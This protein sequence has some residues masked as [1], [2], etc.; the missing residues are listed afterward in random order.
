M[1]AH[2]RGIARPLTLAL[3]LAVAVPGAPAGAAQDPLPLRRVMLSTGGVAYLEHEATVDGDATLPLTV[4]LAQVD[5][6]LKSLV[7]Y[8]DRGGVATIS[9]PGREPL[10]EAF[11]ELP[12]GRDALGS[13]VSLLRALV[14]AEVRVAGARTLEGRIL[15]VTAE[16]V[17][18]PGGLGK[19]TRHRVSVVVPAQG[20][21]QFVLEEADHVEFVD[22]T[23]RAQVSAALAAIARHRIQDRRTLAVSLRGS[24]PRTVRVGYVVEAPLWKASYRLTV[25]SAAPAG[26]G[27]G[28]GLLQGWAIVENLSGQDWDEV[29]LT[30]VSGNPVTFRQALY[31]AYHVAR[32]EVPV[33]V[34]GRVL[35][36]VDTG[37][38]DEGRRAE[39]Q[40]RA[41]GAPGRAGAGLLAAPL[42][43][44]RPVELPAAAPPAVAI[45]VEEAS[46]QV[47]FRVPTPV[48]LRS[49]SSLVIPIASREVPTERLALY[50]AAASAFHPLAAVRLRNDTGASLPPGVLTLY[51]RAAQG[52]S[53]FVGDAR[54]GPLPAGDSRLL[55]FAVDQKT[56]VAADVSSRE[57]IGTARISRGVLQLGLVEQQTTRYRVKA[58]AEEPRTLLIEHPRRPDWRL[59]VPPEREAE[60]TRDR[61]RVRAVLAP[62]EGAVVDVTVERPRESRLEIADMSL[63]TLAGYARTGA[64]DETVRKAFEALAA[65]RRDVDREQQALG[66]AESQRTTIH[67]EQ[68]RIRQNLGRVPATSDLHQRYL[69][70]LKQQEDQLQALARHTRETQARLRA[71]RD[72][73]AEAIARL[74]L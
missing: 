29:E 40:S 51:E 53:A 42:A 60:V 23:L 7:V 47:L 30:L 20:V 49:G 21:R 44:Q 39:V 62:G 4:R 26:A 19:T 32:P 5:D 74:E 52:E 15:G 18:L 1:P 71:A 64:L 6:V 61:Y 59:V 31:T 17:A 65:L 45:P 41:P 9:L 72:R 33:E 11:R 57:V 56:Q 46:S 2:A 73:L 36:R 22:P 16:E 37:T 24:G 67:A 70:M 55:S 10:E 35:P 3:L 13:P 54:L 25:A 8:D 66:E 14:G 28:R 34:M 43:A 68:D 63:A 69:D 58:P 50:E 27:A 12:F 48:S 38:L